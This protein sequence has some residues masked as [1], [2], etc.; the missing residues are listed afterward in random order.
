MGLINKIQDLMLSLT[1]LTG[2]N[3]YY[4]NNNIINKLLYIGVKSY[5]VKKIDTKSSSTF[6]AR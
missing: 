6:N 5:Y 1:L 2:V 3:S 4:N